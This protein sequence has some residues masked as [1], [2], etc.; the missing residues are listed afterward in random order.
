[1]LTAIRHERASPIQ[2]TQFGAIHIRL[3]K[4]TALQIGI[5]QIGIA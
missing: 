3:T 2:S 4:P 5:G 1:M